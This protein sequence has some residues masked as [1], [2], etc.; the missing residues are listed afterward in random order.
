MKAFLLSIALA[1]LGQTQA[2]NGIHAPVSRNVTLPADE[3]S[4]NLTITAKL[5]ST[6]RQVK[7]ALQKAGAP[8]PTVVAAGIGQAPFRVF[9]SG[10]DVIYLAT[11]SLPARS[12]SEV[13][14]A[15]I[16]LG[17]RLPDPLTSVQMSVTYAPSAER[18][19]ATRQSLLPQLRDEAQKEAVSLAAASGVTLGP[20]KAVN[21]TSGGAY[22]L[23]RNG[24]FTSLS[25]FVS[26]VPPIVTYTFRLELVFDVQP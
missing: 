13:T 17:T 11:F 7:E 12:S 23:A 24:D 5:D 20:L 25:V 14:R 19:E 1:A 26:P 22:L 4:F 3:A 21:D 8:N 2:L 9:N 18:L 6:A 10:A 15:L 16:D